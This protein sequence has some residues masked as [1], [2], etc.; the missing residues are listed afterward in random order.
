MCIKKYPADAIVENN[1]ISYNLHAI[2]IY[3][4]F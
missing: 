3:E 2:I 1:N 4:L